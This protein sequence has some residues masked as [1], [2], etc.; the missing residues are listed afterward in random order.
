MK[1]NWIA[2]FF[3]LLIF[4][5]LATGTL[6]VIAFVEGNKAATW[7]GCIASAAALFVAAGLLGAC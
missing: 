3:V 2:A 1:F 4:V 5:S 6:A 7:I